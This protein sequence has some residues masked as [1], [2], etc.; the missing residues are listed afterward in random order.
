[1]EGIPPIVAVCGPARVGK[2]TFAQEFARLSGYKV[3]RFAETIKD[4]AKMM[5][6]W[7]DDII[8][9]SKK[10]EI[11]PEWGFSPR[12]FMLL[13]G[14]EFMRDTFDKDIWIKVFQ[15]RFGAEGLV[16]PDC[17]FPN[18]AEW[19]RSHGGILVHVQRANF[20]PDNYGGHESER[21]LPHRH[22]DWVTLPCIDV[23]AVHAAAL[24]FYTS[25]FADNGFVR[26]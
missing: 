20:K 2:D 21:G 25:I 23:D 14:T 12:K 19:T 3:H 17:R 11:D 10:E 26:P 5:F 6:G 9:S 22:D 15:K 16:I 24:E 7:G 1:M 8:E 18:E 13:F 4:V